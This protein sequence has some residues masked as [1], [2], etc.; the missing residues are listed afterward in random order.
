MQRRLSASEMVSQGIPELNDECIAEC[1]AAEAT[2]PG[3]AGPA[4][5]AMLLDSTGL[6]SLVWGIIAACLMAPWHTWELRIGR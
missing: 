5:V 4:L 2:L 6:W 1:T 3:A